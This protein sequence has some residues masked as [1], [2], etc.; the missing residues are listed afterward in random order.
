[1]LNAMISSAFNLNERGK[2]FGITS[3]GVFIGLIFGPILG[4]VFTEIL[5]WRTLFYLDTI[6]GVVA[7]FAITR[8][9]HDWKDAEGETLDILGSFILGLSIICIIYAFSDLTSNYSP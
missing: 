5:G 4:G 6:I 7:A 2:A 3:M 9:E 1:N 8:F